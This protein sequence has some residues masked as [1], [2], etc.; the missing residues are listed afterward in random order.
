[1]AT[2]SVAWLAPRRT[3]SPSEASSSTNHR[4]SLH[5]VLMN[6]SLAYPQIW[7]ATSEWNME[8]REPYGNWKQ[9]IQNQI[10]RLSNELNERRLK[11]DRTGFSYDINDPNGYFKRSND[12]Y[13]NSN[14]TNPYERFQSLDRSKSS[15][16][17]RLDRQRSA[18]PLHRYPQIQDEC[19]PEEG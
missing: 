18:P 8:R 1:M 9:D 12:H 10:H 14:N 16:A 17:R 15:I 5:Q 6:K 7:T 3:R 11:T 2:T 13:D 19:M 4:L